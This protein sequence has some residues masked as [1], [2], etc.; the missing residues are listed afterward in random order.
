MRPKSL[1]LLILALGCG[2]VASIGITQVMAKRDGNTAT[3]G[4]ET[5]PI[6][7]ALD[8][9]PLWTPLS[10]QVLK[11]E[12]WPKDKVPQ[13]ALS[14][15]EE[16]DGRRTRTA[17]YPGEPILDTKLFGKGA[18]EHG[19]SVMIPK[20]YR[21]VSVK[22][23]SVSGAGL[24]L[25]GD[26][27]DVAVILRAD[28]GRGVSETTTK[29]FLHD[30]KVFAVNDQFQVDPSTD[31]KSITAKTVSLVV[32][33]KQAQDVMVCSEAGKIQLVMRSPDDDKPEEIPASKLSEILHGKGKGSDREKESL[34]EKPKPEEKSNL[35]KKFEDFLNKA[36]AT[37][38]PIPGT[39]VA[40]AQP[41]QTWPMRFILGSEIREVVMG[42]EGRPAKGPT[43]P[44]LWKSGG[45]PSPNSDT[46]AEP[47]GDEDLDLPPP[48]DDPLREEGPLPDDD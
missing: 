21:L 1:L 8:R 40:A 2:L 42:P 41:P 4:V 14:E 30:I 39:D 33:P 24:I 34:V 19:A 3:S 48:E 15:I 26:R 17:I 12:E 28:P 37:A 44:G 5:Q 23:D 10:A 22:V 43:R 20:G 6:L 32:T 36:R 38:G 16:V 31:E 45:E 9:I 46:S 27:V 25:P 13:G 18:N 7:V 35:A 47:S 29:T 11:L